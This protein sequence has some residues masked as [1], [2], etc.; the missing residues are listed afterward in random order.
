MVSFD[1]LSDQQKLSGCNFAP[2]QKQ[3]GSL[4]LPCSPSIYLRPHSPPPHISIYHTMQLSLFDHLHAESTCRLTR[5]LRAGALRCTIKNIIGAKARM[6]IR[7]RSPAKL[8]G[9]SFQLR[10]RQLCRRPWLGVPPWRACAA[11]IL[12]EAEIVFQTA[13]PIGGC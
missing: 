8:G 3:A 2:G 12:R 7:M 11:Y 10:K 5:E 9:Q 4:L 1:E 6:P 13:K